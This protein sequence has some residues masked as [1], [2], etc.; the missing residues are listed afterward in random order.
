MLDVTQTQ[1]EIAL[2]QK[3]QLELLWQSQDGG[4]IGRSNFPKVMASVLDISEKTLEVAVDFRLAIDTSVNWIF[5]MEKQIDA[6][7]LQVRYTT[8]QQIHKICS[9]IAGTNL[10]YTCID[11]LDMRLLQLSYVSKNE[12]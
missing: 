10:K 2:H 5:S 7:C 12:L 8:L 3:K 4:Q 11:W 6:Q 1:N 9:M